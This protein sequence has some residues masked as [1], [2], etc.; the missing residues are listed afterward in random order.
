MPRENAEP[1]RSPLAEL[2]QPAAAFLRSI[3]ESAPDYIV[4]LTPEGRIDFVNHVVDG[5]DEERAIGSS[6]FEY[7]A[8]ESHE[9]ARSCFQRVLETGKTA[10]FESTGLGPNGQWTHYAS[11]VGPVRQGERSSASA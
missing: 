6:V 10:S 11:R 4:L 2:E 8:P 7:I 9:A 3:L 5:V 1:N